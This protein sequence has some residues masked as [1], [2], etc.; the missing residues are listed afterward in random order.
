[1]APPDQHLDHVRQEVRRVLDASPAWAQL[2]PDERR[3]FAHSMVKVSDYLTQ[4]PGWLDTDAPA[5]SSPE[6]A[7][8]L[9]GVSKLK[10]RLASDAGQVNQDF[11]ASAVEQGVQSFDNL[12][13]TVDF[14][15][16]V[17]G[18][19]QGVF[20]AIVD[21]SMQQMDA[22]KELLM[23]TAKTVDQFAR[24]HVTDDAAREQIVQRFPSVVRI[25]RTDT[26]SR[27]VLRDDVDDASALEVLNDGQAVDLDDPEAELALINGTKLEMAR[28]RQ[29]MMALMVMLGINRIVVTN[30]RINAKVIFAIEADDQAKRM[31]EAG[32]TSERKTDM[33]AA[34]G[35]WS[36]WGA[37]GAYAR[38]Q[39]KT[40]VRSSVAD[41]SE[42]K[43]KVEGQ[44]TGEVR[45][46]FRS[47]TL[48]PE[49]MLE[50]LDFDQ[51]NFFS[52]A[53]GTAPE[54]S[55]QTGGAQP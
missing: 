31:A 38:T 29:K 55:S 13:K 41:E 5:P 49:K 4:D 7:Q 22:Y 15:K 52:Q 9:S 37:A 36:P 24:D 8:A 28:Q 43:A 33:G 2:A 14:P 11:R 53:R 17:S 23:A 26:G 27:V 47:E 10:K 34:A 44:L 30:G 32:M 54:A 40:T 35:A 45:V 50:A 19:I 6:M 21:A 39:H 20:Q 42:S 1:M 16:F 51:T 3:A 25:R 46:N 12:V 18:L 48:P